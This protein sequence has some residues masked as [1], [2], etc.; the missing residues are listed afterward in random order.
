MSVKERLEAIIENNDNVAARQLSRENFESLSW[1]E[2]Q[3][4]TDANGP[5]HHE[6]GNMLGAM[7]HMMGKP[8]TKDFGVALIMFGIGAIGNH[9]AGK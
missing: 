4:S 9:R 7:Y 5:M 2:L 3:E 6:I 8:D 1:T